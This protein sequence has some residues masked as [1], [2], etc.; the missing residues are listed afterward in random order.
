MRFT[1]AISDAEQIPEKIRK[2]I[3]R[4]AITIEYKILE[5][6]IFTDFITTLELLEFS[7]LLIGLEYFVGNIVTGYPEV[8]YKGKFLVMNIDLM[9]FQM[10]CELF[11]IKFYLIA[12]LF[13][14]FDVEVLFFFPWILCYISF[15]DYIDDKVCLRVAKRMYGLRIV[16]KVYV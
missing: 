13:I 3:Y 15:Y 6:M 12:I 4:I 11:D 7:Y 16:N 2:I 10:R 1:R 14:I 9:L 5:K 8:S